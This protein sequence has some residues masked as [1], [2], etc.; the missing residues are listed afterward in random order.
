MRGDIL[1]L[2]HFIV[3]H[4]VY[5]PVCKSSIFLVY[6]SS[7]EFKY[8][9]AYWQ[10][11]QLIKPDRWQKCNFDFMRSLLHCF[12]SSLLAPF[13]FSSTLSLSHWLLPFPLINIKPNRANAS[14]H[15]LGSPPLRA[16][17]ISVLCLY[18]RHAYPLIH[19]PWRH[20]LSLQS[21]GPLLLCVSVVI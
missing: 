17:G 15:F 6:F 2:D 3:Q 16:T 14:W 18:L 12:I 1:I 11:C 13:S 10:F 4:F 20:K 7:A 19:R 21:D 9:Y 5:A 8:I